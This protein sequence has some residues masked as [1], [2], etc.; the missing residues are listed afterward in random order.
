MYL[1]NW[2]VNIHTAKDR[3]RFGYGV[4]LNMKTVLSNALQEKW[5]QKPN[6]Q[7]YGDTFSASPLIDIDAVFVLGSQWG[8]TWLWIASAGTKKEQP[9]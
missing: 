2:I 5:V 9:L 8:V 7:L 3:E 1:I 4:E 6:F